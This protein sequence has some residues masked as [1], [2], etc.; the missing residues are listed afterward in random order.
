MLAS[1]GGMIDGAAVEAP[2]Q[3]VKGFQDHVYGFLTEPFELWAILDT[4]S[5]VAVLFAPLTNL[6]ILR[7]WGDAVVLS[8]RTLMS[9]VIFV[10]ASGTSFAGAK[11]GGSTSFCVVTL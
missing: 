8:L 6:P 3:L 2:M 1:F 9:F 4:V 10:L 11:F 7:T 5:S